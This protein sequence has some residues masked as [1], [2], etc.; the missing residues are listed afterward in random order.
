MLLHN[1]LTHSLKVEQ[2]GLSLFSKLKSS[3]PDLHADGYAIAAACLAHDLGHPPFGHAGE[4]ELNALVVCKKHRNK[5]RPYE[6]RRDNPCRRCKLE[7]GF[8]GNAQ[9]F[10]ILTVLA[11]RREVEARGV[12]VGLDLTVKTLRAASKYPW[13]RGD[14]AAKPGK[15]GAYDQDWAALKTIT[16]G[17]H[18]LTVE[19]EIMDWADDISYAVHD[20]EDFYRTKHIP[21]HQYSVKINR[22]GSLGKK[23][24]AL[25]TFLTYAKRNIGKI[26]KAERNSFYDLLVQFPTTEFAGSATDISRLEGARS[27]MLTRFINGASIVDGRLVR[28]STEDRVNEIVKQFIWYHVIDE[29]RLTNIQAG[30]RRVLR[31][32]FEELRRPALKASMKWIEGKPLTRQMRRLPY[33]LQRCI[34]LA[35]TQ[36]GPYTKEERVYRGLLDYLSG[37]SDAEAYHEHAVMKGREPFGHL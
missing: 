29:P 14:H 34:R 1:R 10:R 11:V 22:D 37:L 2:V 35:L 24:E 13:P 23:S 6:E 12:P 5:V 28:D 17:S 36:S 27:A 7:D 15:W 3:N 18:E 30:Q 8:E 26:G 19:A 32:L 4:M 20:I 9:S 33:A 31:E 16:G 21:L 25:R